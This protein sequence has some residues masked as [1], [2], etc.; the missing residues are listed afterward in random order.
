MKIYNDL[1]NKII[2]LDNLFHSWD[3]FKADKR[4]KPDVL[5]FEW[6]LERNIFGLHHELRNKRYR[7]SLYST[8]YIQDPKQRRI[9]KARVRDRIL[10]HAIFTVLNP[11]FEPTFISHSFSC[12]INK[13]THKGVQTLAKIL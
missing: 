3:E 12:R 1:F 11:L 9:N 5:K 10:H 4:N 7:H 8:F 13:G 6:Y 2:S